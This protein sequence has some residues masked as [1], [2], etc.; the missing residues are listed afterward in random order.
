MTAKFWGGVRA[1]RM[2]AA[3]IVIAGCVASLIV[4]YPG[5][6]E[7][8]GIMQLAEGKSGIYS[9]W[10]PPVMS[11]LLGLSYAARGD[12]WLF[13]LLDTLMGFGALLSLLW[14]TARPGWVAAFAALVFVALPQL[15][16][17]QTI[18]WKDILFADALLAGFVCLAHAAAHWGNSR[19]RFALLSGAT[20]FIA[21]AVL[22]RQSGAVVL[23]CAAVT[24]GFIAA[25]TANWRDGL[26]YG[27][28]FLAACALLCFG[29]NAALQLR[30]SAALG[31]VE[32][33]E[34][35]Q[36][37]DMAGML[38][39]KPDLPLPIL[40]REAPAMEKLLR[41]KGP[42]LYTP[43][44]HDP[45]TDSDGFG[46]L[47]IPSIAAVRHQWL[48]LVTAHPLMYL[49]CARR[50]S[51]GCSRRCIRRSASLI[52]WAWRGPPRR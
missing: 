41:I 27:F 23:P 2:I 8:D 35:L 22:T 14:L 51:A 18:V 37:Y 48:A 39:Q 3:A 1:P 31:A 43:A 5:H 7:Y 46:A 44:M 34:D 26:R 4:N 30:A 40:A 17:F 11:W 10:H 52:Q 45:L 33:F 36:L 38:A 42:K 21:L 9:N 13:I 49:R 32:Q 29:A 20:L 24:L 19:A 50:I 28:G 15:F 6:I 16:L 25:Q 47:I 12:G